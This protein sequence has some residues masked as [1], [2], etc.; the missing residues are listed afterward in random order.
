MPTTSGSTKAPATKIRY[1]QDINKK[2]RMMPQ[3]KEVPCTDNLAAQ[4]ELLHALGR[5]L[6]LDGYECGSGLPLNGVSIPLFVKTEG[7][8]LAI[9]TYHGILDKDAAEFT[10]S[11]YDYLK[12]CDDIEVILLNEYF[13]TRNLP[14]AYQFVKG[15]LSM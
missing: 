8:R 3:A 6:T 9:G 7:R 14:G 13:L 4:E 5:L 12:N 2:T 15:K 1:R 11:L 10:H